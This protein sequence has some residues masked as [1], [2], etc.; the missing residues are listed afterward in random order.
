M[1]TPLIEP[2]HT[3]ELPESTVNHPIISFF[4]AII[5]PYARAHR[6][7]EPEVLFPERMV[8]AWHDFEDKKARMLVGFRHAYGDDPQCIAY[9]LHRALPVSARKLGKPFRR[10]TH[11]HF[12][13]GSEVPLWSGGFVRWLLPNVGAVPIDHVRMDSAGMSRIRKIISDG[14]YPLALAPEGH[15]T[16]DSESIG[17]L[18]TGTARFCFWCMDDLDRQGRDEKVLFLPISTFYRY[19]PG[20]VKALS[21][22]LSEMERACGIAGRKTDDA[23]ARLRA[24]AISL[25]SHLG[26]AYGTV[27]KTDESGL[28]ASLLEASLLSGEGI[29]G[30]PHDGESMARI[31]RIRSKAWSMIFRDDLKGLDPLSADIARRRTGEA[32]YAMRHMET[33]E[34]LFHVNL[35]E[36]PDTLPLERYIE[37]ANNLYDTIERVKGGTLR[38][39]ANA[40]TKRAV[41]VPGRPI[42]M[43][44]Y[45]A[46]YGTD[47]KAALAKAT[48]DFRERYLECIKEYQH[49][50]R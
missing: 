38:N 17:E 14:E 42:C 33:A 39:R 31:Y 6:F 24:V 10:M 25:L 37:I 12:I 22:F 9:A 28:Q 21:R 16:Y 13:Y 47:R 36:I 40:F 11:A 18:E 43:N 44:D 5:Q 48:A 50:Y 19:G 26:E 27:R 15:V 2:I 7:A 30:L 20:S 46:L 41:V 8:D 4:R 23:A 34:M 45:R 1:Y 32:W 49:V 35:E 3:L 29:L